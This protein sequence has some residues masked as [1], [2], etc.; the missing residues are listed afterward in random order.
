MRAVATR[1]IE[2]SKRAEKDWGFKR[3][4]LGRRGKFY[5]EFIPEFKPKNV[6]FC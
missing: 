2:I 4:L 3:D 6:K 5:W 1:T